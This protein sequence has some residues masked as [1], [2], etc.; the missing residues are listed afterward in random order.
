M[1]CLEI[2]VL[3]LVLRIVLGLVLRIV[4]RIILRIVLRIILRIVLRIVHVV[5][6]CFLVFVITLVVH[7]DQLLSAFSIVKNTSLIHRKIRIFVFCNVQGQV[8]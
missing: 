5:F 3:G 7:L 1:L 2:V 6:I 4:L 8:F